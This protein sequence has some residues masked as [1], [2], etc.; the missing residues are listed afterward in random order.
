MN[1]DVKCKVTVECVDEGWALS[2]EIHTNEVNIRSSMQKGRDLF[3]VLERLDRELRFRNVRGLWDPKNKERISELSKLAFS[4]SKLPRKEREVSEVFDLEAWVEDVAEREDLFEAA[5][6]VWWAGAELENSLD[7][8]R[9]Y[10]SKLDDAI[11][12]LDEWGGR[13][14]EDQVK[15]LQR[16]MEDLKE[17]L[18]YMRKI[19]GGRIAARHPIARM[20]GCTL[21]EKELPKEEKE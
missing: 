11:E 6:R 7:E 4:F 3:E 1:K 17:E 10:T 15:T 18:Q 20:M 13:D 19:V 9:D 14:I 2:A 8:A 5:S 12:E 21:E 16:T